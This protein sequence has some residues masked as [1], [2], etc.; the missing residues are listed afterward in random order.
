MKE[1]DDSFDLVIDRIKNKQIKILTNLN[2]AK[3]PQSV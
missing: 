2:A 3:T 1:A